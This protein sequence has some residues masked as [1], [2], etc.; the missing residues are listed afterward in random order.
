MQIS[1]PIVL[2]ILLLH[3]VHYNVYLMM[4][5]YISALLLKL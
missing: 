3:Y 1:L 4:Q 2:V 5:V